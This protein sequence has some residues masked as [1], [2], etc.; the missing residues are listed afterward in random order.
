MKRYRIPAAALCVVMLLA[1]TA[2]ADVLEQV[3]GD[4]L[5]V[6]KINNLKATSE[7]IGKLAQDLGLAA[8]KPPGEEISPWTDPLGF[9]QKKTK[10][11]NG[12]NSAGDLGFAYLDPELAGGDEDKSMVVLIPVTDYQAFLG[13]FTDAKTEGGISEVKIGDHDDPGFLAN[14]GSY[15]ALSPSRD[16][17]SKAP[18]AGGL[19]VP[20]ATAKDVASKD[21]ILI[22]NFKSLRTKLMP[23]LQEGREKAIEGIQDE[24]ASD[25]DTAKFAPL[26]KSVATQVFN[27]L[28]AFVRDTDAATVGLSLG[29][30]GIG[31][32]VMSDFQP[33][34]Y[35][36]QAFGAAEN[37]AQNVLVG[38]PAGKY[39]LFGGSAG[40]PKV[41]TKVLEDLL[42][43]IVKDAVAIGPDFAAAQDY[44]D[45]LMQ[46][47]SNSTGG[48][49]GMLAPSGTLGADAI[50]Q[51]LSVQRGDAQKMRDGYKQMMTAQQSLMKAVGMPEDQVRMTFTPNART[52]DGISFDSIQ[53]DVN[54]GD[55]NDPGAKMATDMLKMMYGPDGPTVYMGIVDGQLMTAMG[56]KDEVISGAITATQGKASPLA[57]NAGVKSVAANLPK[58]SVGTVYV[59][60]DEIVNTGL[61]YA[62]QFGFPMPI[63]LPPDL[64]PIGAAVSTEGS[65]LRFDVYVPTQLV[66]SLVAAGLQAYMGMRGGPGGGGGL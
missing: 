10:M 34:S 39:L 1:W 7:K 33:T 20:A 66:Q 27:A 15:A 11:T 12:V 28:E 4:A 32:S 52:V 57:D 37:T 49:F 3:P 19:K 45:G 13:N 58:Q 55:P 26:V 23:Q 43:P 36:G 42:S 51:V 62:K 2:R 50:I 60:L 64:P 44:F 14:W 24:I 53:S 17:V 6:I 41:A 22:A 38:L 29:A 25:P 18:A 54:V 65:A 9:V 56:I 63:Q 46:Y 30:D 35:L 61:S 21:A 48:A 5:F 59:Q 16:V 47:A 8:F 40:D 31:I